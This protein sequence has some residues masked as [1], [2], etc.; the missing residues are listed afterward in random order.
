MKD[1]NT[2]FVKPLNKDAKIFDIVEFGSNNRVSVFCNIVHEDKTGFIPF[3]DTY[4]ASKA[5]PKN[6]KT[7]RTKH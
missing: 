3:V 4:A 2:K 5:E 6:H 7:K 1:S